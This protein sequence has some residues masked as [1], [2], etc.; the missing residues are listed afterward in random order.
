MCNMHLFIY[1]IFLGPCQVI[2]LRVSPHH[3]VWETCRFLSRVSPLITSRTSFY[4][5]LQV[6]T[7]YCSRDA[8]LR[9]QGPLRRHGN[10]V[11][12]MVTG[13]HPT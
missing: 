12:R 5:L 7:L 9:K 10:K 6:P 3:R 8:P 13:Y 11:E 2:Q 4:N 1:G